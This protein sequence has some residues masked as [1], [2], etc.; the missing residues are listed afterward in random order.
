M[1]WY[2]PHSARWEPRKKT[3]VLVLTFLG[4]KLERHPD[5][6]ELHV[7]EAIATTVITTRYLLP[8]QGGPV[9]GA[10]LEPSSYPSLF[11]FTSANSSFSEAEQRSCWTHLAG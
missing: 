9:T 7:Q 1:S 8:G 3:K 4:A 5:F 11:G 2:E 6:L 10:L